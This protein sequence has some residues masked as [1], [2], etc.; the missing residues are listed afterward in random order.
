MF[1]SGEFTEKRAQGSTLLMGVNEITLRLYS[2]ALWR[3]ESKERLGK[4]HYTTS[5]WRRTAI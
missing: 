4:P 1:S 3:L 5:F 2:E